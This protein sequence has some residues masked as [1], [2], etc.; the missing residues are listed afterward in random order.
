[1]RSP[2]PLRSR[3]A[4]Y[5]TDW[6]SASRWNLEHQHKTSW[7]AEEGEEESVPMLQQEHLQSDETEDSEEELLVRTQSGDK[8][9]NFVNIT[10]QSWSQSNVNS[11]QYSSLL[12]QP[13]V[14][15]ELTW[16]GALF[17]TI[18]VCLYYWGHLLTAH[19]CVQ[20]RFCSSCFLYSILTLL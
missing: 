8:E 17:I 1:M 3:P 15:T 20:F 5:T 4:C 10:I 2:G 14:L 12:P 16:N 9:R 19:L 7:R 13:S 11:Q 18:S 6:L